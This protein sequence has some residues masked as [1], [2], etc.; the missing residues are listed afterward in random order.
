MTSLI[1]IIILDYEMCTG[2]LHSYYPMNVYDI[3]CDKFT[4]WLQNVF[5]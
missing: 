4:T 5:F 2:G 1:I 3:N